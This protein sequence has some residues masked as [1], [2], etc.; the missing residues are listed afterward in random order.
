[1]EFWVSRLV[2]C[3][4]SEETDKASLCCAGV[5]CSSLAAVCA[6]TFLV[7]CVPP[8]HDQETRMCQ[9]TMAQKRTEKGISQ[10]EGTVILE[11][12]VVHDSITLNCINHHCT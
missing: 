9:L 8:I 10:A 7:G 2:P 3:G 1:M 11:E 4:P 5:S 12:H 6:C